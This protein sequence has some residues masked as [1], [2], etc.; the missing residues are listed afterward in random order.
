[1]LKNKEK[2]INPPMR[3][4][5]EYRFK[6]EGFDAFTK[7]PKQKKPR[8]SAQPLLKM[9]VNIDNFK[10]NV[11]LEIYPGDDPIK[12]TEEFCK[13]HRLGQEKKERL[14]RIIQDRLNENNE[15]ENNENNDNNENEN[16]ENNENENNENENNENENQEVNNGDDAA[17]EENARTDNNAGEENNENNQGE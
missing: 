12:V 6:N 17:A 11:K 5:I 3:F 13:K 1:M 8:E 2:D 7:K 15:N 4:D 14:Q 9:E 16:N 10:K